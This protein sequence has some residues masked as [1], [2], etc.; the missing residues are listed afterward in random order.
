MKG[1]KES[2]ERR[3]PILAMV[4]SDLRFVV[5]VVLIYTTPSSWVYYR[6]KLI[7]NIH[8]LY[9]LS[10]MRVTRGRQVNVNDTYTC[11]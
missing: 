8:L 9:I 5:K 6:K 7:I 11:T 4:L 3:D 1:S 2:R 10:V